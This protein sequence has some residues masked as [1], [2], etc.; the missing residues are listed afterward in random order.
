MDQYTDGLL[1]MT[2]TFD[3]LLG[4]S[5]DLE[6]GSSLVGLALNKQTERDFRDGL[7]KGGEDFLAYRRNSKLPPG[8]L[9]LYLRKKKKTVLE[10]VMGLF[11][12]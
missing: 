10:Q 3:K 7:Q 1:L 12:R 9:H 2:V 5:G 11:G 4:G 6:L 8:G